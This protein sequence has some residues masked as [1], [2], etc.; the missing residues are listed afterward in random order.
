MNRNIEL[1]LNE[2]ERRIFAKHLKNDKTEKIK[3]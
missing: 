1:L 3:N 2:K